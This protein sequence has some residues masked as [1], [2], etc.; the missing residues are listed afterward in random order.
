VRITRF[1]DSGT[2]ALIYVAHADEH[3]ALVTAAEISRQFD[4]PLNHMA[5]VVAQLARCGSIQGVRGRNGGLLLL[6]DPTNLWLGSVLQQLEGYNELLN[7]EAQHCQ[8]SKDCFLH[9]NGRWVVRILRSSESLRI[10]R[11]ERWRCQ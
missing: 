10:S 11:L 8:L 2:R 3:R 1:S 6:A 9:G 5:K 4:I 7:C